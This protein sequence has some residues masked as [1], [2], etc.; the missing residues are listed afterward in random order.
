MNIREQLEAQECEILSPYASLSKNTRGRERDEPLCDIRPAYQRDRDRILHCKSFRRLK[1]KTQVFLSPVGDHYRTRLTHT[2]EVAQ[3]ARTIAKSLRLNEELAEAIA[4]GHDLGHT[5]FGH[6]GEDALNTVCSEG[7]AHYKQSVRVVERL[8]KEGRGL[9][10][11]WEVRDGILN[12]RTS[13][14]PHTLEGKVVR[15]SDKIAYINHDIDDA[16]R[17]GILT[18]EML[19]SPYTDVLGHTVRERLNTLIHSIIEESCGKPEILMAP[20]VE[21]AMGSLR[22][23]MFENVYKN[24]VSKKED[25]KAQQLLVDLF[26]YYLDHVDELPGE[27]KMLMDQGDS[28]ERVVCDYIAGM[29]DSYA[30]DTFTNLF[31]PQAWK[32]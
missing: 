20:E 28:K 6:A 32:N 30:I 12:H 9:N 10:L 21:K 4:L 11:T 23:F 27:Y 18:E 31:V 7:F 26:G 24:S 5:P 13:G 15:L 25:P 17:A 8:E 3:I 29:S 1:H 22:A 16:I 2:L 14:R 19:P